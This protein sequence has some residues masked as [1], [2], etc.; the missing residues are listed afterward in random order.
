MTA[1]I[2]LLLMALVAA[3]SFGG[4]WTVKGWKV[5]AQLERKDAQ[6]AKINA[7]YDKERLKAQEQ[8]STEVKNNRQAEQHLQAV[9]DQ[10]RLKANEQIATISR[11]ADSLAVRV[12][13]AEAAAAT[14]KLVSASTKT[15]CAGQATIRSDGAELLRPLGSADVLEAERADKIRV[16]L[17][18]CYAQYESARLEISRPMTK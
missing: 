10:E 16:A 7:D 18:A 13:N 2:Q 11:R 12:R 6:I 15:A 17:G 14:A 4:G 3:F 8:L 9:A 5:D 1:Q